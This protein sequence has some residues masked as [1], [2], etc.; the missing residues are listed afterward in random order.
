[1]LQQFMKQQKTGQ[2]NQIK[3][4]IKFMASFLSTALMAPV[5]DHV[6]SADVSDFSFFNVSAQVITRMTPDWA[7]SGEWAGLILQDTA[8]TG[9]GQERTLTATSRWRVFD[10]SPPGGGG[11]ALPGMT[12]IVFRALS[13]LKVLSACRLPT[14]INSVNSL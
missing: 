14:L 11:E 13:T 10:L 1:M 6:I 7:E 9:D 3:S 2:S 4:K 12:E 5:Q 8:D